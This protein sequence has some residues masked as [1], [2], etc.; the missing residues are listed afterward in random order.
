MAPQTPEGPARVRVVHVSLGR[1]TLLVGVI[2]SVGLLLGCLFAFVTLTGSEQRVATRTGELFMLF[3][4]GS[5]MSFVTGG[6]AAA[7]FNLI[8]PALGGLELELATAPTTTPAPRD[9]PARR[10]CPGCGAEVAASRS[11]CPE[12]DHDLDDAAQTAPT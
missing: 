11:F 4:I 12:C 10:R 9:A 7:M 6:F 8:A 5:V 2:G 3:I 1:A